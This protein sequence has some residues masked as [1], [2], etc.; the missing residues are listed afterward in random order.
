MNAKQKEEVIAGLLRVLAT[1]NVTFA[2]IPEVIK[3]LEIELDDL[4]QQQVI[5]FNY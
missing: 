1:N 3:S 4:C 5:Q 2:E